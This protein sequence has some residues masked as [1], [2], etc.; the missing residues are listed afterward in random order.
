M[1]S[2]GAPLQSSTD[3][4]R[5]GSAAIYI[6]GVYPRGDPR[7]GTPSSIVEQGDGFDDQKGH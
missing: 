1:A 3:P 5:G 4:A 2:P 6:V 7:G